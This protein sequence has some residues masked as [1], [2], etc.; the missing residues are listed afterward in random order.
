MKKIALLLFVPA[1][2]LVWA[3]CTK[4]YTT[5][6]SSAKALSS[7]TIP[8]LKVVGKISEENKTIAMEVPGEANITSLTPRIAISEKATISPE[9]D[10]PQDFSSPIVYTVTA[11]DGT[12]ETYTVSVKQAQLTDN[13]DHVIV[14][15]ITASAESLCDGG[16]VI[17]TVNPHPEGATYKWYKDGVEIS[18]TAKP[19]YTA[20]RVGSYSV[21]IKVGDAL[22]RVSD[23]VAITQ[24]IPTAKPT[25]TSAAGTTICRGV[26][27]TLTAHF[28]IAGV[29]YVWYKDGTAIDGA[30]SA[31][32]LATAA[33]T[34]WV[35]AKEGLCSSL[36]SEKISLIAGIPAGTKPTLTAPATTVCGSLMLTAAFSMP[37]ASYIWYK[38]GVEVG[39]T[40]SVNYTITQDG[41]YTVA[42]KIGDCISEPSAE[43]VI[44]PVIPATAK[45]LLGSSAA[46]LC[47]GSSVT[48]T[49]TNT[50]A[51]AGATYTW[52][53]DGAV[54]GTT[55]EGTR[56]IALP[57]SYTVK[58]NVGSCSSLTS[59][60]S[61]VG[62]GIPTD[63]KPTITSTST[64]LCSGGSIT[65]TVNY[66]GGGTG[67]TY[68]WYKDGVEVSRGTGTS[69]SATQAGEYTVKAT[70]GACT[71]IASD[72]K[73]ITLA[74]PAGAQP[75]LSAS[76]T[77]L[78]A[79]GG[80]VTLTANFVVS[81]ATYIWY[82]DGGTIS[83]TG[84]TRTVAVAGT[85]HVVAKVGTCNSTPSS[86]VVI[87]TL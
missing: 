31:T 73:V 61:V 16:N 72:L 66:T 84:A 34:Y 70:M 76:A 30:T 29:T 19:T 65:L 37:G 51:I 48:L 62:A 63:I 54:L 23:V 81:G 71:T 69:Y 9:S 25:V 55:A 14:P 56:T 38:G 26:G 86:N 33:G 75:T 36:A 50:P 47:G 87:T 1:L 18:G 57:G 12:T 3:A 2:V 83:G 22:S 28:E 53:K 20:T 80:T 85:Y 58:T 8:A 49:A 59:D 60:P 77:S 27:I 13:D 64:Q 21:V 4:D 10:V 35:V 74:M 17:L 46:T 24:F 79:G 11:E 42:A 32:Y 43:L 52:Y 78:T 82:K 68:V 40:T 7:F 39:H 44:A 6:K 45:P 41:S 5:P 67:V 15:V